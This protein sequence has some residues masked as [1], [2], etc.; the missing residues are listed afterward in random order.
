MNLALTPPELAVLAALAANTS[1]LSAR[2]LGAQLTQAGLPKNEIAVARSS[3]AQRGLVQERA[4]TLE[5]TSLGA[6]ALL[7]ISAE[8]EAALDTS[9]SSRGM[10]ECPSIPWLTT[11][12]TC[13]IDAVSINYAVEPEALAKLLP[14][15]LEPE[16]HQGKAWVQI[17][18]SSLRDM[19]PQGLFSLFGVCFYQVSYRAAVRYRSADGSWRRG[20]YF[21]RSETNHP[22]MRAVGNKLKEFKFHDF[23]AAHMTMLRHGH[24]LTVGV[25]PEQASSEGKLVG[26]FDTRPLAAPPKGSVWSGIDALHEPLVECFDAFGVDAEEGYVYIL[27][28]DRA[29]WNPTF[30][31]PVELYS[32]YVDTGALGSGAARFDSV[33]HVPRDCLYRWRP[34]RRERWYGYEPKG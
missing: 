13:W 10:E 22:V 28:I 20:G 32:E 8:I 18:M 11:V 33:L 25:E 6:R 30:V 29:P 23:G 24:Q 31:T 27:T 4:G 17:L 12:Q 26:I 16:L 5:L 15:P 3:A 9:P 34:L 1:G 2:E 7:E 21:V 19:R 14:F